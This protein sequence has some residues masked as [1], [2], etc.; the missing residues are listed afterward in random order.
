MTSILYL[1]AV[2][3]AVVIKIM[4]IPSP[5]EVAIQVTGTGERGQKERIRIDQ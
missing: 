2:P 1:L 4:H 5:S 3:I